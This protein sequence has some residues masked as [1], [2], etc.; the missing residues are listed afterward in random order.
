[1]SDIFDE[2]RDLKNLTSFVAQLRNDYHTEFHERVRAE[3]TDLGVVEHTYVDPEEI[4][5]KSNLVINWPG[6]EIVGQIIRD[7]IRLMIDN[8][9]EP[10]DLMT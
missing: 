10:N 2:K 7:T 6:D 3:I 4:R 9:I 1:M 5:L 8:D